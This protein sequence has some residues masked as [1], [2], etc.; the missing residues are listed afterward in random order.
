[1]NALAAV[2]EMIERQTKENLQKVMEE[3]LQLIGVDLQQVLTVT[4]DNGANMVASVKCLKA[5]LSHRETDEHAPLSSIFQGEHNIMQYVEVKEEEEDSDNNDDDEEV[6]L[7]EE[8]DPIADDFVDGEGDDH[9]SLDCTG[10]DEEIDLLESVRCGAHTAQL[11]VWDVMKPYKRRLNEINK[12][13]IK[14]RHKEFQH[15]FKCYK[16]PA[17]PKVNETRWNVWYLLLKYV[18]SLK[19]HPIL[20]ML[21]N[22]D[23]TIGKWLACT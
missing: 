19:E 20:G 12:I 18:R 4:H 3:Q 6:H 23:S 17:P 13:C 1:M 10:E 7:A 11:A 15:V 2:H 14:M 16:F 21:K 5:L 9:I 8:D 22:Q